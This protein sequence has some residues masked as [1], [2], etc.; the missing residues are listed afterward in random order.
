[1]LLNYPKF[2]FEFFQNEQKFLSESLNQSTTDSG[3]DF[4]EDLIPVTSSNVNKEV[5]TIIDQ[6]LSPPLSLPLPLLFS[7]TRF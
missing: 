4:L 5:H 7:L 3:F 2:S 6:V 1:V